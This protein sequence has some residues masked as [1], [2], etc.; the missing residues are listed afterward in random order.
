M[1]LLIARLSKLTIINFNFRLIQGYL[2]CLLKYNYKLINNNQFNVNPKYFCKFLNNENRM[3]KVT[4]KEPFILLM[5]ANMKV[6]Y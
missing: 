3:A 6:I 1:S 4:V 2:Y 5:E